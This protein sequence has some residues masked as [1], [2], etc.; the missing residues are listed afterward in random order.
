MHW[1]T[2]NQH[3]RST[4]AATVGLVVFPATLVGEANAL[5]LMNEDAVS[6]EIRVVSDT[7]SIEDVFTIDG[8]EVISEICDDGCILV[9][10]DG[11]PQPFSGEDEVS[12]RDGVFLFVE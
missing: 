3:L 1:K 8:G 12:I 6:H 4:L 11:E 2:L 7:G 5:I 9:L 10:Q